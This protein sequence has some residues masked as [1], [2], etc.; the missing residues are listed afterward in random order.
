MEKNKKKKIICN[1]ILSICI[2]SILFILQKI[3]KVGIK[4]YIYDVEHYNS[5][6]TSLFSRGHYSIST[7]STGFRGYVFPSFMGLCSFIDTKLNVSYS[8]YVLSSLIFTILFMV[9]F[10][11]CIEIF[12]FNKKNNYFYILRCIFTVVLTIIFFYGLIIYPLTDLYAALICIDSGYLL[13]KAIKLDGI[14]KIVMYFLA[15]MMIYL[16]Y[17][18]RTI[19]QLTIYLFVIVIAVYEFKKSRIRNVIF[20]NLAYG[21]GVMVGAIP[22]FMINYNLQRFISPWINN[23]NL[24]AQQLFWGL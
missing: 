13:Y 17:N 16:A 6:G 5:I 20:S 23:G 12:K 1:I 3:F 9:Y 7:I 24:F 21:I 22:Q 18:I 15:G 10:N 2:F 11:F 8:I 14:K 19:Y 4:D